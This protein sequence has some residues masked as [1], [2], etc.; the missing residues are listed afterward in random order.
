MMPAF[1][2]EFGAL[3]AVLV[4]AAIVILATAT[5]SES[6]TPS[7]GIAAPTALPATARTAAPLATPS[8]SAANSTANSPTASARAAAPLLDGCMIRDDGWGAYAAPWRPV[9]M[10]EARLMVPRVMPDAGY[11]LLLHFHGREAV[12]KLLAPAGLPLVIAAIDAGERS[13]AYARRMAD[14]RSLAKL[15]ARIDQIMAP[16]KLRHLILSSWSAGYAA[17]REILRAAGSE[18]A[19]HAADA[20]ILLDG[21]HASYAD[22]GANLR[23][24][25]VAPFLH[26]A[27]RARDGRTLA[28]FTHSEIRPPGYASTKRVA[29]HLLEQL[30]ARRRYAGLYAS[31]NVR[32]KTHYA[33]GKL[34]LRGYTGSDRHAHCAQLALL[35]DVL[36]QDVLPR[37]D[38]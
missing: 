5:R 32:L 38:P 20:V 23:A 25:D 26:L 18:A 16:A 34:T 30:G 22:D 13:N 29:D 10:A 19:T 28:V 8:N 4:A 9:D 35:P 36:R 7:P 14:P 17:I 3:L 12:R 1:V 27:G 31:H 15:L 2:R 6:E 33:A 24:T 21:V 37:L 11:D